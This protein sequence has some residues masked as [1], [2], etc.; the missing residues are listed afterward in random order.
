MLEAMDEIVLQFNRVTRLGIAGASRHQLLWRA[1]ADDKGPRPQ[2]SHGVHLM[3]KYS[4]PYL[5]QHAVFLGSLA[6]AILPVDRT[7][8]PARGSLR[9]AR[10]REQPVNLITSRKRPSQATDLLLLCINISPSHSWMLSIRSLHV[11]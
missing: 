1:W 4:V 5:K 10:S 6:Q 7:L 2:E 9:W 11:M 8:R 3:L